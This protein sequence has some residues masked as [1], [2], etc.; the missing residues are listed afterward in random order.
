MVTSRQRL[1]DYITTHGAISV[2]E[3]SEALNM[4]QA[5]I[6]RHLS[7]LQEQGRIEV[8]AQRPPVGR[9]RPA[10][11][12]GLSSQSL[13][14]NLD[15][16]S[17]ALLSE[18]WRLAAENQEESLR[19]IGIA[20][21]GK[22]INKNHIA[23]EHKNKLHLTQRLY[24]TVQRLNKM[25]YQARWEARKQA[26]QIILENCPYIA[27]LEKHPELCSIDAEL[28]GKL[29]AEKVDQLSKLKKDARGL[30]HCRFRI[31]QI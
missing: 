31:R 23:E 21:S 2:A 25:C 1:L 11:I 22:S 18:L 7:I 24:N 3:T 15:N 9:G 14:N 27:I 26:P 12:F 8:I 29:L 13:G 17:S 28:L 30:T 20:I 10:L 5:N 4:T 19:N 16:L 6:R